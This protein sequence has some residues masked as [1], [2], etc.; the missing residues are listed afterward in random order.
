[1]YISDVCII[2][3]VILIQMGICM[4]LHTMSLSLSLSTK[5]YYVHMGMTF[6]LFLLGAVGIKG[7]LFILSLPFPLKWVLLKRPHDNTL[8]SQGFQLSTYTSLRTLHMYMQARF[9]R[10]RDYHHTFC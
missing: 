8:G 6:F 3:A 4:V 1:M 7:K 9:V 2:S 5:T 10:E